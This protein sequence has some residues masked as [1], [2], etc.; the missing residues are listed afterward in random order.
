MKEEK[1]IT[2]EVSYTLKELI[3]I[4]NKSNFKLKQIYYK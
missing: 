3:E 2:V 1:E 4:L